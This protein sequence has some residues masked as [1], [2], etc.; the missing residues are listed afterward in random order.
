MPIY[1]CTVEIALVTETRGRKVQKI[2]GKPTK[3]VAG[4]KNIQQ[5]LITGLGR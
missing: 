2:K 4:V 1:Y 5:Y 3:H